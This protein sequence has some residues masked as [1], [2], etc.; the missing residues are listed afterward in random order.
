MPRRR[1]LP[2][3]NRTNLKDFDLGDY[4]KRYIWD[5]N[6]TPYLVS[7]ENLTQYQARHELFL[8]TLFIG[9]FFA[10]GSI[11]VGSSVPGHGPLPAMGLFCFTVVCSAVLLGMTKL[12]A[13]ALWCAAGPIGLIVY[14]F[15]Y[16][17]SSGLT[18]LDHLV[19]VTVLVLWARYAWRVVAI[20]KYFEAMP[21][22]TPPPITRL[23]LDSEPADD[24]EPPERK[25]G[26]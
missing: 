21:D 9:V 5:D 19:I 12:H 16:G 20:A 23:S 7:P 26:D 17:F 22:G 2:D 14:V 24:P 13:A 4:F 10:L 15:V 18:D 25:S 11:W 1:W 3:P 8:Y 6:K